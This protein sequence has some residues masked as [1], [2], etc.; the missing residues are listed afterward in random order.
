MQKKVGILTFHRAH[1]YGAVLQCY[2]LQEVLKAMGCDVVVID[3]RQRQIE[4][5]SLPFSWAQFLWCSV[6]PR[7]MFKYLRAMPQRRRDKRLFSSFRERWIDLSPRCNRDSMPMDK[8]L[9]IIG[10]DQ[11]WG[12]HCTGGL[13]PVYFGDFSRNATSSVVGYAI[14][15]NS[16]SIESI[17]KER[18]LDYT[19]RFKNL[20]FRE[21]LISQ[22][23]SE[24]C[25]CASRVDI[26]PTLLAEPSTW[27]NMLNH[28]WA[29]ERYV[30]LYEV[31]Y[32]PT[33][34]NLLRRKADE[35]AQSLGCSVVDL[36]QISYS[37]EDFVSLF[38]YAQC[39]V[40]SSFHAT[41]FSLIF[42]TPLQA[43]RLGDGHDGRYESL[44]KALGAEDML[45]DMNFTPQRIEVNY[46]DVKERLAALRENSMAY[47]RDMTVEP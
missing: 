47:L 44:L 16:D 29:E 34:K 28:S 3:F 10:S 17:D 14:S 5:G 43:V 13:E 35:L 42:E 39:V 25:G 38:K 32:N 6:R 21:S 2:A 7:A 8:D 20:S 11:L 41:V 12:L 1:N 45:V 9:Y 30:L 19:A 40:T 4:R 18:L 24:K 26:D 22:Q 36:S 37:V 15:S 31:R 23:V 33:D 46:K 27:E